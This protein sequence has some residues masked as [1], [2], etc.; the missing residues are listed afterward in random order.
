VFDTDWTVGPTAPGNELV[1][2]RSFTVAVSELGDQVAHTTRRCWLTVFV[3][4]TLQLPTLVFQVA[5]DWI[6]V[7]VARAGNADN[8][9]TDKKH[10]LIARLGV[11]AAF[12][13]LPWKG[14]PRTA[15]GIYYPTASQVTI[16]RRRSIEQ[17]RLASSWKWG[18]APKELCRRIGIRGR[19]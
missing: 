16:M 7:I 2:G 19:S 11:A 3:S 9:T 1:F 15:N 13:N 5:L 14:Q 6:F 8:R 18:D 12:S 10:F 4:V 17:V